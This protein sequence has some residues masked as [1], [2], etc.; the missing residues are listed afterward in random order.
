V[1]PLLVVEHPHRAPAQRREQAANDKIPR[2][3]GPAM[4]DHAV[5]PAVGQ[6]GIGRDEPPPPERR[7]PLP[8]PLVRIAIPPVDG[9]QH[10]SREGGQRSD[11][12]PHP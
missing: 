3:P 6:H 2:E 5:A 7:P 8:L 1:T 11:D 12:K 4:S 9:Q 10:A